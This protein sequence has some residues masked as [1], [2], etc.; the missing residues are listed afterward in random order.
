MTHDGS[1]NFYAHFLA[2]VT[3]ATIFSPLLRSLLLSN[4]DL[5]VTLLPPA[6]ALGSLHC[7]WLEAVVPNFRK[8]LQISQALSW[9]K[10]G[11]RLQP[12]PLLNRR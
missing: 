9:V 6:P 11:V 4:Y 3:A 10:K 2:L 1:V 7:L 12:V 5:Q 8:C